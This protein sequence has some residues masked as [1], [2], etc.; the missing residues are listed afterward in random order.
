MLIVKSIWILIMCHYFATI[1]DTEAKVY[2]GFARIVFVSD[3]SCANAMRKKE[4]SLS[5][6]SMTILII[7]KDN[8]E[9]T[10]R[11]QT[12][13]SYWNETFI[14]PNYFTDFTDDKISFDDEKQ[15]VIIT[16]AFFRRHGDRVNDNPICFEDAD[17]NN[18]LK[19]YGMK[20]TGSGLDFSGM[21]YDNPIRPYFRI[22]FGTGEDI[23]RFETPQTDCFARGTWV[24]NEGQF[25]WRNSTSSWAPF[26]YDDA[27][28]T[29]FT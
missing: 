26:Y 1:Q 20:P 5:L 28:A 2:K 10:H 7:S 18:Y 4:A 9:I 23:F 19:E 15:D 14:G 27:T 16:A 17:Y 12:P 6:F 25:Y 22:K 3:T 8:L 29:I 11:M 13:A 21:Y 24:A